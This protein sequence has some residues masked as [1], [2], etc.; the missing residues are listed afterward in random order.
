MTLVKTGDA[1]IGWACG[2]GPDDLDGPIAAEK[3]LRGV[4]LD[5]ERNALLLAWEPSR[6]V[7]EVAPPQD[8]TPKPALI[9]HVQADL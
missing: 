8:V 4:T 7:E 6:T 9:L 5:T 3:L 1:R 2:D